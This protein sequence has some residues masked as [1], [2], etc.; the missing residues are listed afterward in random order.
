MPLNFIHILIELAELVWQLGTIFTHLHLFWLKDNFEWWQFNSIIP[1]WFDVPPAFQTQLTQLWLHSRLR[2]IEQI[3]FTYTAECC[4]HDGNPFC[5]IR[6]KRM[7]HKKKNQRVFAAAF[8]MDFVCFFPEYCMI[9]ANSKNIHVKWFWCL[10]KANKK[11]W[12]CFFILHTFQLTSVNESISR[13]LLL[14]LFVGER[15]AAEEIVDSSEYW[16][17]VYSDLRLSDDTN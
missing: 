10:H 5:F 13:F 12:I 8:Y 7:K 3:N 4:S 15:L 17:I 2:R 9:L 16:N 6:H 14:T 1:I 11:G